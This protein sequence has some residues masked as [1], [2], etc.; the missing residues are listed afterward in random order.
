MVGIIVEPGLKDKVIRG[1]TSWEY[2]Y[3]IMACTRKETINVIS[4][5]APQIRSSNI[6]WLFTWYEL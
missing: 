3:C 2:D 5:Y 6:S 4:A 1:K